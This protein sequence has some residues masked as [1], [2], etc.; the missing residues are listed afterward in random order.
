MSFAVLLKTKLTIQLSVLNFMKYFLLNIDHKYFLKSSLFFLCKI[1][2]IA[3]NLFKIYSTQYP[4]QYIYNLNSYHTQK[5]YF[6]KEGL[7]DLLVINL[8]KIK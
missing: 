5:M 8:I 2:Y 6:Q 7:T 4:C 3:L 1:T